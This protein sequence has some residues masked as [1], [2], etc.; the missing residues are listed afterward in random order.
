MLGPRGEATAARGPRVPRFAVGR[1]R[2]VAAL[3]RVPP[4]G[5]GL[6]VA[7]AGSGKSVL[8]GQWASHV[9][10]AAY[11]R[12]VPGHDDP[13]VF[14]RAL[15][16]A[17]AEV[18]TDLDTG[19][20][21]LVA[22]AGP[23]MGS[24]F[25]SRLLVELESL[26]RP[27]LV[28]L[29]DLHALSS[30]AIGADLDELLDR[31]PDN[32]RVVVGTRWD[33]PLRIHQLRLEGR[34]VELRAADLAFDA[35][36]S[37]SLLEAVSARELTEE[38]VGSL[39]AR[40]DG[41]AVGLQLAAISLQRTTD[42]DGFLHD[43]SGSD[44]LVAEYLSEEVIDELEPNVR[45]FLLRT[46]ILEWLEPDLCDAVSGGDDAEEVLA[47]LDSRS[48]FLVHPADHGDR[49]RYHHLFADL[50]QY[51]LRA[52]DVEDEREC[53]RQA[54]GF[55]M[56]GGHVAE[57]IEQ[58]VAAEEPEAVLD[59]VV[60]H[61][62]PFFERE[63]GAT[64]VRWLRAAH[65]QHDEPPASLELNLLAAEVA[66][67][68]T[69]AAMES[70]R[71][72]RRRVDLDAREVASA[73]ALYACL[74]MDDLPSS[75]VHQAAT[76]SLSALASFDGE[77]EVDLLGIGGRDTVEVLAACLEAIA[78]LFDGELERSAQAL[79]LVLRL[80]GAQYRVWR[81]HVLGGLAL[82]RAL[83]GRHVEASAS[84][85]A[86]L[87]AAESSG[88]DQHI[89]SGFA[90]LALAVGALDQQRPE[91]L[92]LHLHESG[93]RGQRTG[94]AASNAFQ[95]LLRV[96]Q[97]D[98]SKGPVAALAELRGAARAAVEPA[99][100]VQ[101]TLAQEVRLLVATDQVAQARS[102]LGRGPVGPA[103]EAQVVE[104]ELAA[105]DVGAARRALGEIAADL[106]NPRQALERLLAE[107]LVLDAEGRADAAA[108]VLR[109]AISTAE[110]EQ[111]RRPFL[112][113][114][115]V[116]RLLRSEA[117]RGSQAFSKTIVDAAARS[118]SDER[119]EGRLVEPLTE[120][121]REVL[122]YLPTRL[123]NAE[124]AAALY[125]SVNT[126]KSHLRHIYTK[127]AVSDRDQAVVRA[128][129]LGLL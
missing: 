69:P 60:A 106:S 118:R 5:L 117:Q 81:M 20:A 39:V 27:V 78:L 48:L 103:V 110:A 50:L 122:D 100:V 73:A 61:G 115:G 116:M 2:L 65:D 33:P 35:E 84:A 18:H 101:L 42:V 4:A 97:V 54:A 98:A 99:I 82:S 129:D 74:G 71:R 59:A 34:L 7:P 31:L 19:V 77:L 125:I 46:S 66:A 21:E 64:L 51:R 70:Y 75:E 45:R 30:S 85:L 49:L 67:H 62:Q 58:L 9:P 1:P 56:A 10:G 102:L 53:R 94:R 113:R 36:E 121:E 127:L 76:E 24:V 112:Q 12:V 114:P 124:L 90:H 16:S 52:S 105:G 40:T 123:S 87:E 43:F 26:D 17:L 107:V 120:R 22:G 68:Q 95:R 108:N 83:A 44:K 96:E 57:S 6:V 111:L 92:V 29:D 28:V 91:Q 8:L 23:S 89:A 128:S 88:L 47:L 3:D 25:T 41:W 79:D 80:P 126:L 104:L 72:L 38:Q 63:Q 119:G 109:E 55:L 37:R 13:V 11:L 14:A 93:T 15:V 86:A 32:V